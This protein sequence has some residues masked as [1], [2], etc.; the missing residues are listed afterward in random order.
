LK[1]QW[2]VWETAAGKILPPP[3]QGTSTSAAIEITV[4]GR[5]WAAAAEESSEKSEHAFKE[6]EMDC[7]RFEGSQG[8]LI[9]S[10]LAPPNRAEGL[11]V[12]LIRR[13]HIQEP[14][15]FDSHELNFVKVH[16]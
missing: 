14:S 16:N 3:L 4:L 2:W 6:S 5:S 13:P 1:A 15:H 8:A 11:A 7:R 10:P 12:R 9:K